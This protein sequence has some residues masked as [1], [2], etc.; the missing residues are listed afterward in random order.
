MAL[1]GRHTV[2]TSPCWPAD[3]WGLGCRMPTAR[4]S[5][6]GREAPRACPPLRTMFF[7]PG[8]SFSCCRRHFPCSPASACRVPGNDPN[9]WFLNCY[10]ALLNSGKER[11]THLLHFNDLKTYLQKKKKISQK[12]RFTKWWGFF[13]VLNHISLRGQLKGSNASLFEILFKYCF[14]PI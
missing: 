1:G 5:L 10:I 12:F 6:A 14:K 3:R 8:S 13:S 7:L 9:N 11:K 4:A 2:I